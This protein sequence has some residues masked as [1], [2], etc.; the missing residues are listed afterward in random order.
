MSGCRVVAMKR[1]CCSPLLFAVLAAGIFG[2]VQA[3]AAAGLLSS[4]S[5]DVTFTDPLT[6]TVT[7]TI[8]YDGTSYWSST[9]NST[10]GVRYS[11]IGGN[12][13]TVQ[14]Y[15][16]GLDFRS[17]FVN[18][19]S[20]STVYARAYSDGKIYQQ[21]SP[22]V[23]TATSVSL[24]GLDAQSSVVFN[25]KGTEY[26]ALNNGVVSRFNLSGTLL[27]TVSLAG[28]GS[29]SE[30]VYPQNRG[31]A[32]AGDYWFT[33]TG[34][35]TGGGTLSVW[36]ISGNRIGSTT[37]LGAGN[38]FASNFS[39]SWANGRIFVIDDTAGTW[40]GYKI[41]DFSAIPEPATWA[42]L[43]AGSAVVGLLR[44]RRRPHGQG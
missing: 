33:Y 24:S 25:G 20:P 43:G 42:M 29:N 22:G 16:P 30:N 36:D 9:G 7:M 38:T 13:V 44:W 14:T 34:V 6:A 35:G 27:G 31:I 28:W 2:A 41:G 12:G 37:L 40:R 18:P 26:L 21:T 11:Q 5:A 32:A 8:A 23:F 10:S 1:F 15:S 4:Y 39:L 19:L 3:R 17:V